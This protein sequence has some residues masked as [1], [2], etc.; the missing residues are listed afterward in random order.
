MIWGWL[1][2]PDKVCR[3]QGSVRNTQRSTQAEIPHHPFGGFTVGVKL[4]IRSKLRPRRGLECSS[5][6]VLHKKR[7]EDPGPAQTRRS[8][9]TCKNCC[10]VFRL[11]VSKGGFWDRQPAE[12]ANEDG[13]RYPTSNRFPNTGDTARPSNAT[14]SPAESSAHHRQRRQRRHRGAVWGGVGG[15]AGNREGPDV[16]ADGP[17]QRGLGERSRSQQRRRW[18][19]AASPPFWGRAPGRAPAG[20]TAIS[21]HTCPCVLG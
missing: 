4:G 18:R 6:S 9:T 21:P 11:A 13:D 7:I 16:E 15:R 17:R 10:S 5:A 20:A 19:S 3:R 1:A 12:A 8:C 2:R 14:P